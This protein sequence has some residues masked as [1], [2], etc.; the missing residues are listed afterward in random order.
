[1]TRKRCARLG[2]NSMFLFHCPHTMTSHKDFGLLRI[3]DKDKDASQ[4]SI[5]EKEILTSVAHDQ[6]YKSIPT[7][8]QDY[9]L[10]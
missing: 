6:H 9:C 5:Q 4:I 3:N 1:M 8:D 10:D 2:N 7:K